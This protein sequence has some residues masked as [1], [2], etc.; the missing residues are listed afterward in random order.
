[1]RPTTIGTATPTA[2]HGSVSDWRTKRRSVPLVESHA[3]V[4]TSTICLAP[5]SGVRAACTTGALGDGTNAG[6]GAQPAVAR[7]ERRMSERPN[8]KGVMIGLA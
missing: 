4:T 6:A 3:G 1:M 7:H 5:S 8:G 2:R